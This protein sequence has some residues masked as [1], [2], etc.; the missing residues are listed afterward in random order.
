[1]MEKKGPRWGNML[2]IPCAVSNLQREAIGDWHRDPWGW[3]EYTFL[4]KHPE[5]VHDR[6][7]AFA[8]SPVVL[9][10]VPKENFAARPAVVLDPTDRC[11][12]HGIS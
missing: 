3:P 4:V 7:G 6:L 5:L 11:G 9:L 12:L 2:D 1:M 10:D 8:V